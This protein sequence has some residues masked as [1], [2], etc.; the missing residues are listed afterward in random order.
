MSDTDIVDR[1]NCGSPSIPAM[2]DGAQEIMQLRAKVAG[3]RESM[4]LDA[5]TVAAKD[6]RIAELEKSFSDVTNERDRARAELARFRSPKIIQMCPAHKG[7]SYTFT[8][9]ASAGLMPIPVCPICQP[10]ECK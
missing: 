2:R 6:R 9:K 10:E 7:M 3:L 4:R 5:A 8:V 1:L